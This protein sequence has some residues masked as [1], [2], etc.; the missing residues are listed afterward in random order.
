MSLG[1]GLGMGICPSSTANL[2]AVT[3]P[4]LSCPTLYTYSLKVGEAE[5]QRENTQLGT[6]VSDPL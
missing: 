3:Q 4:V 6:Q 1:K 5:A 2:N